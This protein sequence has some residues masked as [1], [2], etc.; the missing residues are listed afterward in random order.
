[1]IAHPDPELIFF[2]YIES[3]GAVGELIVKKQLPLYE[4]APRPTEFF[5]DVLVHPSGQ[6]A[7][8][9]CYTGKLKIIR[10]KAGNYKDDFDASCV[11][12]P[13]IQ[14]DQGLI[15]LSVAFRSLTYSA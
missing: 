2:T 13:L 8:V 3:E 14:R 11:L 9:S 1:M 4:R 10:I 5:N 6:L 7:L 12:Y 15:R